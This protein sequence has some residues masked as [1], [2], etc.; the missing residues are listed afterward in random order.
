VLS[1]DDY[2]RFLDEYRRR[3]LAALGA[4]SPYLYA[5]KRILLWG[6]L[7][8]APTGRAPSGRTPTEFAP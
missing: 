8:W 5:F 7:A 2:G 4:R 3:L 1:N 6:Q